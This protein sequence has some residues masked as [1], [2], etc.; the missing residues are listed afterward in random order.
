MSHI[1]RHVSRPHTSRGLKAFAGALPATSLRCRVAG[2]L[3]TLLL[4][5]AALAESTLP[6]RPNVV[7]LDYCAD[8]YVLALADRAQILGISTGPDDEFSALRAQAV[9]VPRVRDVSEDVLALQPDLVVR[10]YGGGARTQAFYTRL[11]IATHQV[12]VA[13]DFA[14]VRSAIRE[15]ARA[16]GHPARGEALI[17]RMDNALAAAARGSSAPQALYVTPGGVTTGAGTLMHEILDAA[18]FV[19]AAA[20]TGGRGWQSLP[21]ESLVVS[22]PELFVTGFFGMRAGHVEH[23]TTERHPVLRDLFRHTPTIHLDGALLSCGAWFMAEAAL[24]AR[25]QAD[26]LF[27]APIEARR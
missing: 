16:L 4:S 20:A 12:A 6:D 22:P 11:G 21:L 27:D 8:Q 26:A 2:V 15:T 13:N 1:R 10:V 18:G 7:S 9:G 25:E 24:Q 19:N 5:A 3:A 17:A 14:D 23:W